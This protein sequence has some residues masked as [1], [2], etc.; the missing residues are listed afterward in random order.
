VCMHVEK[1]HSISLHTL[2]PA[3][4]SS[5]S[6]SSSPCRLTR[7]VLTAG[8]ASSGWR[9]VVGDESTNYSGGPKTNPD[10]YPAGTPGEKVST[11]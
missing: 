2:Q 4:D 1:Q 8:P 6:S 9:W 3:S 10:A 5:S 7:L 11:K